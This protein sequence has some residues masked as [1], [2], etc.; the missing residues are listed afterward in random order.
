MPTQISTSLTTADT[1][2]YMYPPDADYVIDAPGD[3]SDILY[4]LDLMPRESR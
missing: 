4:T 1:R 3:G 2:A